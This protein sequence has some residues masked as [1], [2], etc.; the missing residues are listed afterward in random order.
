M[1]K[2]ALIIKGRAFQDKTMSPI[3]YRIPQK[4]LFC[5]SIISIGNIDGA[6]FHEIE[7]V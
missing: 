7:I 6:L 4:Q 3:S 5:M 2:I 1:L